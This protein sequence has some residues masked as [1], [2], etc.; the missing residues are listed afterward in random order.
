MQS[1]EH[2]HQYICIYNCEIDM[3]CDVRCGRGV[4]PRH[5]YAVP[6]IFIYRAL[7]QAGG[8]FCTKMRANQ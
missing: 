2:I 6:P 7:R 5:I 4:V 1:T 8:N 3:Q